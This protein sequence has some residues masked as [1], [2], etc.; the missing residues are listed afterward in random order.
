MRFLNQEHIITG[1]EYFRQKRFCPY[2]SD[3]YA[4]STFISQWT[5]IRYLVG[6]VWIN[7]AL[8]ELDIKDNYYTHNPSFLKTYEFVLFDNHEEKFQTEIFTDTEM[9]FISERMY[10]CFRL[11]DDWPEFFFKNATKEEIDYIINTP[12][13]LCPDCDTG[14]VIRKIGRYGAFMGCDNYP[15]CNYIENKLHDSY[16]KYINRVNELTLL[17]ERYK[18]YINK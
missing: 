4:I 6:P 13:N 3:S 5:P 2:D 1:E 14:L 10:L 18:Q 9:K 16:S 12:I 17:K 15:N 8:K 7:K 11:W